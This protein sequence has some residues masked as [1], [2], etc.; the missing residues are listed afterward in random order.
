MHFRL[1][2]VIRDF[3]FGDAKIAVSDPVKTID[4][5]IEK[6]SPEEKHPE[7]ESGQGGLCAGI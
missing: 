5:V 6:R 3:E 7:F 1:K 4:V 2:Y